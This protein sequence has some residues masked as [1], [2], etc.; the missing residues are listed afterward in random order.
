MTTSYTDDSEKRPA[1]VENWA[2]SFCALAVGQIPSGVLNL[3]VDG[4]QVIGPL[5]GFGQLW[6]KTYSVRFPQA[7]LTPI[8]VMAIWKN[9]FTS[10]FPT[11]QRFF[12]GSQGVKPGQIILINALMSGMPIST[13]VLVLYADD[14][15]FT[16]IT[17]EGHPESGWITFRTYAQDSFVICEIQSMAR[18][19]DPLYELAFRLF[20]T[21][22]QEH[23]WVYVLQ[24]LAAHLQVS[25]TIQIE[26]TCVDPQLQWAEAK[27]IWLNAAVRTILYKLCVPVRKVCHRLIHTNHFTH[28]SPR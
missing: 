17:P 26:R 27:N 8:E 7:L 1:N 4:R 16:L 15:S 3:N 24:A 10:F 9:A 28:L 14:E 13:G 12:P 25:G 22:K 11:Q 21:H 5:Q 18:A 2:Q 20:G 19:N 23:I 6:K